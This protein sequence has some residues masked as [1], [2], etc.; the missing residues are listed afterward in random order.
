M[1]FFIDNIWL[2]LIALVSGGAL[3]W[4]SLMRGK[5]TLSTF[6]ATRMI[7]RDK[8]VVIDVRTPEE[9]NAGHVLQSKNIPLDQLSARSGELDKSVPLLI[10]CGS[11]VRATRAAA[12]L[13]RAGFD[14]VHVLD[15]GFREWQV[16]GL[17]T[18][19][20]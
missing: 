10:V 3:L 6:Q 7:N 15:G 20:A 17:P 2:I 13:K 5:N 11:G 1:K 8:A 4:P 18:S 14:K 9:F 19:K 12:M 16:Q